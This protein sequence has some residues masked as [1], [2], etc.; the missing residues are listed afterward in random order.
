[1]VGDYAELK[2]VLENSGPEKK[3]EI[4]IFNGKPENGG[5]IINS[6]SLVLEPNEKK[7]INFK[8]KIEKNM[9][10][11]YV[12]ADPKASIGEENRTDN[13]ASIEIEVF[14]D[15]KHGLCF[16]ILI[17]LY[18]LVYGGEKKWMN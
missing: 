17:A 5:A 14:E 6:T 18:G 9:K 8:V 15:G 16:F 12:I 7:E 2:V 3:F 13:I 1:R 11:F 4:E 10:E